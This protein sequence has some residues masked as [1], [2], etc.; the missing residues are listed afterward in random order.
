MMTVVRLD[1]TNERV[2]MQVKKEQMLADIRLRRSKSDLKLTI[3]VWDRI[4]VLHRLPNLAFQSF[5][6]S[7]VAAEPRRQ[8]RRLASTTYRCK[9][10][11]RFH[12]ITD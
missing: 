6:S 7:E 4:N 8:N 3:E 5:A 1:V 12:P 10:S 11:K 9:F 2:L